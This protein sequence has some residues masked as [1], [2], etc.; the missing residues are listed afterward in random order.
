[1]FIFL[2]GACDIFNPFSY[3]SSQAKLCL[4]VQSLPVYELC[5]L[6]M[7]DALKVCGTADVLKLSQT[8]NLNSHFGINIEH[9]ITND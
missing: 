2:A 7:M 1:M 8:P 5:S 9:H 4:V 6:T 3:H